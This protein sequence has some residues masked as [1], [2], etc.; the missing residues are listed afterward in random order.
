MR[1]TLCL[2]TIDTSRVLHQLLASLTSSGPILNTHTH[3][4]PPRHQPKDYSTS[5]VRPMLCAQSIRENVA[6]HAKEGSPKQRVPR[7]EENILSNTTIILYVGYHTCAASNVAR[8]S[9]RR[10]DSIDDAAEPPSFVGSFDRDSGVLDAVDASAVVSMRRVF[11][12]C[13]VP[14]TK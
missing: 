6:L 2:L 5:D 4:H 13:S 3:T 7:T 11:Q 1:C 8:A 9:A 14:L 12:A 10:G